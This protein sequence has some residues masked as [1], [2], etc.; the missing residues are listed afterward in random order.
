MNVDYRAAK[1]GLNNLTKALSAEFA[2]RGIRV[3]SIS[4]GPVLLT[5]WWTD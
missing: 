1:A 2:P 4:P 3:N 5:P